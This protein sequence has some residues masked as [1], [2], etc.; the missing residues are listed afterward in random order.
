MPGPSS[1]RRSAKE[2]SCGPALTGSCGPSRYL[3]AKTIGGIVVGTIGII[4]RDDGQVEWVSHCVRKDYRA[5]GIGKKMAMA[6]LKKMNRIRPRPKT[7]FVFTTEVSF[8]ENL[9]FKPVDPLSFSGKLWDECQSCP[10][11]PKGPGYPP[12]SETAMQYAGDLWTSAECY[13]SC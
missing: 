5:K 10:D 1:T 12:C 7:L 9:G 13:R 2:K 11:G 4:E 8:Y 3:V 6:A